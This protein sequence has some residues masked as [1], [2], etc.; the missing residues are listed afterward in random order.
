[1]GQR[2]RAEMRCPRW[3]GLPGRGL[4]DP[5]SLRQAPHSREMAS[6][7]TDVSTDLKDSLITIPSSPESISGDKD[8]SEEEM[9][10][11]LTSHT[12]V[13]DSTSA[14]VLTSIA[15]A[16]EGISSKTP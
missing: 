15:S 8:D 11:S 16:V 12:T 6:L 7:V 3:L 1:M 9:Y 10:D 13:G 2:E 5:P 4:G 14:D